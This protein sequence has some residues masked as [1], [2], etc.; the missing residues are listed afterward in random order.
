MLGTRAFSTLGPRTASEA[1]WTVPR[2]SSHACSLMTSYPIDHV[3]AV[4]A[5]QKDGSFTLF[6]YSYMQSL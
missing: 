2:T 6:T 3:E 5:A 4:E 1:T